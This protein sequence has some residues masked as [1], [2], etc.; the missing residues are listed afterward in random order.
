MKLA[1]YLDNDIFKIVGKA[2]DGLGVPA[3]VIGGYVRDCFLSRNKFK[4]LDF[5]AVGSGIE[6]AKKTAE[7]LLQ[8]KEKCVIGFTLLEKD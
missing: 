7:L 2:A 8:I 1:E 3:Y 4:D 6:L 5:V